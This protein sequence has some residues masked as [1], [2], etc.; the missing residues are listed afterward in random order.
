MVKN[1][2][3]A[4]LAGIIIGQTC[5]ADTTINTNSISRKDLFAA[6]ALCGIIA[7]QRSNPLGFKLFN[8]IRNQWRSKDQFINGA[9]YYA[10]KMD[11]SG[12]GV[13]PSSP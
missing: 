1:V 10:D 13:S 3:I 7:N 11:A 8:D 5:K 9:N 2:V 6:A 4:L 12:L